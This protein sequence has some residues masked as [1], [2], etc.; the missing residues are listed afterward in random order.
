M[1]LSRTITYGI[2]ATL[3][4]A[5]A[6]Q[7]QT[8]SCKHLARQGH[9][10]CRFLLQVL[11]NLVTGGVLASHRGM[12]G[13][14]ILARPADEITLLDIVEA[15]DNSL[16]TQV[17]AEPF[18]SPQVSAK[19]FAALREAAT[20]ERDKLREFTIADLLSATRQLHTPTRGN[21]PPDDMNSTPGVI[22]LSLDS[23]I[24]P[25]PAPQIVL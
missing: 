18:L 7:G 8:L 15:L 25:T 11:R 13:G 23:S 24:L 21:A 12:D 3:Q 19:I 10:P 22:P 16:E 1:K 4:L 5:A 9:M 20:A 17:P 2:L 6:E 14:Y